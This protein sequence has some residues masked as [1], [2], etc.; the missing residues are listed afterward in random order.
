MT[1]NLIRTWHLSALTA[2]F[3]PTTWPFLLPRQHFATVSKA[4]A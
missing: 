4:K 2:P 3:V 1:A